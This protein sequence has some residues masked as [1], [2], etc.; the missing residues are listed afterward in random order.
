MTFT[1]LVLP[2]LEPSTRTLWGLFYFYCNIQIIQPLLEHFA[3]IFN[4]R[5][6]SCNGTN[7]PWTAGNFL[8]EPSTFYPS[9]LLKSF[10]WNRLLESP[11]FAGTFF[12]ALQPSVE[13]CSWNLQPFLKPF[14]ETFYRNLNLEPSRILPIVQKLCALNH[15]KPAIGRDPKFSAAGKKY[16]E[17][18][19]QTEAHSLGQSS[20]DGLWNTTLG[21]ACVN[22]QT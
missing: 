14:I 12:W 3:R 19:N 18:W 4:L 15:P 22:K 13:T 16:T 17:T 10:C 7:E 2:E 20:W 21:T 6:K 8:L 9:L 1:N 11:P 5:W